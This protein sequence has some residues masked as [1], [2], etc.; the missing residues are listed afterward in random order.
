MHIEKPVGGKAMYFDDLSPYVYF[1]ERG[2]S[3]SSD[4]ASALN[5]GWLDN[6]HPFSQAE[7]SPEFVTRLW[8]FCRTPINTTLGWHDCQFCND[9]PK[10]YLTIEQNGEKV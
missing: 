8:A 4:I 9:D 7:P 2:Q 5:I 3:I 10:T 1:K 6:A